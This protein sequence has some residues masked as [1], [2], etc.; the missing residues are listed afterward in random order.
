VRRVAVSNAVCGAEDP[1]QATQLLREKLV[2]ARASQ[3]L[4]GA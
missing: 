2:N 3:T 4:G 1:G